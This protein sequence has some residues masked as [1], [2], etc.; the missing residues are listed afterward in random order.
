M[1]FTRTARKALRTSRQS[2]Q[3]W[4]TARVDEGEKAREAGLTT[5]DCPHA[6]GSDDAD[7]WLFGFNELETA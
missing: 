6:T 1:A 3:S 4:N 2:K 5:A 7:E